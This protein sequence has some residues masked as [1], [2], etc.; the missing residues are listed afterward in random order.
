[1]AGQRRGGGWVK[2]FDS[3]SVPHRQPTSGEGGAVGRESGEKRT[4]YGDVM[5]KRDRGGS[6]EKG[7][8]NS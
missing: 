6:K 5:E 2:V 8:N 3:I 1:M 4:G 7:D